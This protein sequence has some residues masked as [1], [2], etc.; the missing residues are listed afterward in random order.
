MGTCSDHVDGVISQSVE[1]SGDVVNLVQ[2]RT[3]TITYKCQDAAGNKADP[4]IRRVTVVDTTCPTCKVTGKKTIMREASF[5][6][7]DA[8]AVCTDSLNGPSAPSC[9]ARSTPSPLALTRSP[10]LPP[11]R[12]ATPTLAASAATRASSSRCAP[13]S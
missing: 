11:T 1:V 4:M 8:G 2:P 9:V 6:Y 10:T 7:S 3:Y 13:S 5:T 12:L